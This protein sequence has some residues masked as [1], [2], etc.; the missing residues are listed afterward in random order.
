MPV[1]KY[2]AKNLQ[3]QLIKGTMEATSP[4][5]VRRTLRQNNEFALHIQEIQE[6]HQVYKLK[7]ME[8][9]DFSRQIA[10]MLGSGIT[11]IRA[12]KI[13]EERDIKPA[14]KKVYGVL[15]QEIQRGN[16]LS[17]A[18]EA[19]GGSFPE[20][21]INM[22]K[23]GEASGQMEGTARK[24][25]DHYEK[26]HKLRGKIKS[27]MTYPIILFVITIMVVVLIFTLILPQ[28]FTLFE[29]IELPAITQLM[30]NIS[31]SMTTYWYIYLIGLL[32]FIVLGGFLVT[33]PQ[34]KKALDQFKLKIPKI[35]KLMKIIYTARFARTLSSL[36]S[37]G[38]AMIN[39]LTISGATIGNSY[40]ESQF[41]QA[42]EQVRNGEPLSASIQT[43]E[44]FDAKLVSTIY[45]GEE[46]GNLDS[47][48]ESVADSFDYEAEMATARLVTFIE[49]IMIIIMASIVGAIILS[50]MLPIMTLYQNIG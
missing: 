7:P 47:M 43:I 21:L 49:P 17:Y 9:S 23:S 26:E 27:A 25:A 34:I 35:G 40:L 16:T 37:S 36:Y 46:S 22:Y 19:T 31:N 14:I 20:L 4:E 24:M 8:I 39:A 15:Y 2:T 42:I 50:V 10:S 30:I 5:L 28:F 41:P 38:L 12:I 48:L 32:I 45:I 13:M 3:S 44:G 33:V 1:Y 18:M 11:M 29:G 6:H